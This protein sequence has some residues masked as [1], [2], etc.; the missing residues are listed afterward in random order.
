MRNCG[1]GSILGGRGRTC[2]CLGAPMQVE[3][4]AL[5]AK[6]PV[7]RYCESTPAESD[8]ASQVSEEPVSKPA[9]SPEPLIV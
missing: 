6:L 8:H 3:S 7:W 1:E 5:V 9:S 4:A 2:V